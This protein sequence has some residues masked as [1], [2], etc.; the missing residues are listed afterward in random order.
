MSS[1]HNTISAE[2]ENLLKVHTVA[3][4]TT[5]NRESLSSWLQQAKSIDDG[6]AL[7]DSDRGKGSFFQDLKLRAKCIERAYKSYISDP[8]SKSGWTPLDNFSSD[9]SKYL[10][11]SLPIRKLTEE[12]FT[13]QKQR[14]S[15]SRGRS[16]G[17]S[18]SRSPAR[19]LTKNVER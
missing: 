19:S 5:D 13:I 9:P 10:L 3:N 14:G 6:T 16:K 1:S 2:L 15:M 18:S 8:K 17:A 7:V 4:N 11:I 12:E